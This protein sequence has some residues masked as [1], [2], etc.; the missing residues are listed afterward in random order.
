MYLS[1]WHASI[2]CLNNSGGTNKRQ[3]MNLVVCARKSFRE[4]TLELLSKNESPMEKG[5]GG[6]G[7][8]KYM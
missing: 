6:E 5:K 8:K 4:V 3:S 1:G 7:N 2:I